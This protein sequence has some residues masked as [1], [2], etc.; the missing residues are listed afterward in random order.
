MEDKKI[1]VVKNRLRFKRGEGMEDQKLGRAKVWK[2]LAMLLALIVAVYSISF[3][4][5]LLFSKRH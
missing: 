3:P 5:L 1:V 2:R 4:R